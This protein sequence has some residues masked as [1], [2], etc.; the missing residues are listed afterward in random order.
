MTFA[1]LQGGESVFVDANTLVYHF[2]SHATFGAA[3]T[4]L[5]Q[6]IENQELL[7]FS[8]TAVLG[9]AAHRLMTTEA[10]NRFGWPFAGIG[11]RL[12]THPAEVQKLLVFRR[13]VDEVLR[14]KMQV[15]T[16]PAALL[17]TG[18]ALC[19][20]IGL[21]TNDGV[22]LAVMQANGL[23]NLASGDTDFD[24]VPGITRYAPV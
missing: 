17:A 23:T 2:T 16:I 21:L 15:L 6:R 24:R 5:L 18:A 1:D 19:Q 10:S 11:N 13:A 20:Q 7:G 22:L 3:C 4:Q 14:G 9:E 12:R 8:S